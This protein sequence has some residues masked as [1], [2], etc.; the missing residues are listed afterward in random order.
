MGTII[1]T[2]ARSEFDV[3]ISYSHADSTLV[4]ALD[5]A[6]RSAGLNVFLDQRN[7]RAGDRLVDRIFDGIVTAQAQVVVLSKSSTESNWVGDELSAG[8]S[9]SIT[10]GLRVMPVLIENCQ[11]PNSLLHLKYIDLRDWLTDRSFRR[12]ITELLYALGREYESLEDVALAWAIDNISQLLQLESEFS[13]IA[14]HLDGGI[15]EMTG[16][17]EPDWTSYKHALNEV[18]LGQFLLSD[19]RVQWPREFRKMSDRGLGQ[20]T[21][22][23]TI[24]MFWFDATDL[25]ADE[26][27]TGVLRE[28]VERLHHFFESRDLTPWGKFLLST[29]ASAGETGED[30][31][32]LRSELRRV[33]GALTQVTTA[34]VR[35]A[36]PLSGSTRTHVA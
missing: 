20:V 21:G 17:I 31:G 22:G 34:V 15:S 19:E 27:M 11:I 30:G 32:E 2:R 28:S 29:A 6:L 12:G 1:S 26:L 4:A 36:V 33:V 23:V 9:R 5:V 7:I 25:P 24:V 16:A 8:R 14:A 10:A 3:F 35:L 18:P 13:Y